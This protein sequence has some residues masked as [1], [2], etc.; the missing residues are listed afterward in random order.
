[1]NREAWLEA[2]VE[3]LRN[4][5]KEHGYV[6]PELRVSVGF[7]ST[8]IRK[9]IGECW[10]TKSSADG[11]NQLFISPILGHGMNVIHVLAH[12]IV[13][14]VD[15]N[16]NGHKKAFSDIAKKVGLKGPWKSTTPTDALVTRSKEIVDLIGDYPHSELAM[17]D[18]SVK[19][20]STR[21]L[22]VQ[23]SDEECGFKFRTT[24]KWIDKFEGEFS[25]PCGSPMDVA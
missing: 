21:M 15:D 12:E 25:C 13:H 3:E 9:R 22:L 19:K 14:V 10:P 23:C 18:G 16:Q 4:D 6:V 24:A 20:Q 7:P 2:A 1:M 11:L 17:A 5:F 8:S